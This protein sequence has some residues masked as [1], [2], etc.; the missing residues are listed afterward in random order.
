V[1]VEEVREWSLLNIK[2]KLIWRTIGM[3]DTWMAENVWRVVIKN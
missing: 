2:K 1:I 3:S